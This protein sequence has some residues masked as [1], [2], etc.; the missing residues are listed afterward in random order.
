MITNKK[1]KKCMN[2]TLTR[3]HVVW[4]WVPAAFFNMTISSF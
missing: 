4:N 1:F 3:M 2:K